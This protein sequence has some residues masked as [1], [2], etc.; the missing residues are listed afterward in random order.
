[1]TS[2][3]F[4]A[5]VLTWLSA[6]NLEHGLW[7]DHPQMMLLVGIASNQWRTVQCGGNFIS[8]SYVGYL[9]TAYPSSS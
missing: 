4:S 2:Y 5:Q 7:F 8:C 1:M 3:C 9:L 6:C